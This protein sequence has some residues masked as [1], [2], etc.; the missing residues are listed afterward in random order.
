MR[1]F[2]SIVSRTLLLA[3]WCSNPMA[4]GAREMPDAREAD[5]T[6]II[7]AVLNDASGRW[8]GKAPCLLDLI[9]SH[10]GGRDKRSRITRLV[11]LKSPLAVCPSTHL[12]AAS[13]HRFFVISE[14]KI[15][16]TAAVVNFEYD[17][18][19]CGQGYSY[20]LQKIGNQWRVVGRERTW[21]S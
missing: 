5:R 19:T 17:C 8:Q 3:A 18:P 4:Q 1:R 7:Q 11:G 6:A 13:G 10:T 9:Q 14:P 12:S 20:S 15:A 21:I 2:W 16:G